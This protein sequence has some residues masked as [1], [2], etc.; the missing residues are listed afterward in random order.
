MLDIGDRVETEDGKFTGELV[1]LEDEI[2]YI[3]LDSGVEMEF[4]EST[5]QLEGTA[6]D[7]R[8]A[9]RT[10]KSNLLTGRVETDEVYDKT[11]AAL[12]KNIKKMGERMYNRICQNLATLSKDPSEKGVWDNANSY[13]KLNNISMLLGVK[14][15]R[16]VKLYKNKESFATLELTMYAALGSA[17]G[18]M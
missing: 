18:A 13:Q 4:T 11:F 3:E 16:L 6:A 14:T 12:P 5:L 7:A 10:E 9:E 2:A 8:K 15:E 1:H 17:M